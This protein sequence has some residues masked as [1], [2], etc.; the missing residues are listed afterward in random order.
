MN[1]TPVDNILTFLNL[2]QYANGS[3]TEINDSDK[4]AYEMLKFLEKMPGGFF[5]YR[6]DEEERILYINKAVLRIFGCDT[7]EEFYDITNGTFKGFV[8]HEDLEDVENSIREQ[9]E[10]SIYELDYVEYRIVCKDGSIR[11]IEDYGHF[12]H[13]DKVG[14]IFYVFISDAT[15]KR[16]R[17]LKE[18]SRFLRETQRNEQRLKKNYK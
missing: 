13:S 16:K 4:T 6:A 8:Y 2:P 10:N 5:I 3:P 14:D 12:I 7:V 17:R 9:I 15:E 18:E 11:W 1:S